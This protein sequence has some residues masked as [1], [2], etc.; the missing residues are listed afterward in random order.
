MILGR[1]D[2]VVALKSVINSLPD[3]WRFRVALLASYGS[4]GIRVIGGRLYICL[5]LVIR[6]ACFACSAHSRKSSCNRPPKTAD[7]I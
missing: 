1:Y 4:L 2:R 7:L 6:S 3:K 5:S